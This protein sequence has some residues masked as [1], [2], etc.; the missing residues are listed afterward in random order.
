MIEKY[1]SINFAIRRILTNLNIKDKEVAIDD[2]IEWIGEGLQYIGSYY[3]YCEKPAT[4]SITDYKGE[5]PCDFCKLISIKN[6]TDNLPNSFNK[7]LIGSTTDQINRS[8]HTFRDYNITGNVITTSYKTGFLFIKYLA[9]PLDENGLPMI[10]DDIN[11][12]DALMW[13]CAYQLSMQGYTFKN[14]KLNDI[15][16]TQNKWNR[17]CLQARASLNS[18]DPD[19]LERMKNIMIRFKPDLNQYYN[20]F[21]TLGKQQFQ[22]QVNDYRRNF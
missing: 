17:Y 18:P 15:D 4:I 9:I 6:S 3:Q 7:Q 21:N 19:A 14:S 5:L 13:K 8:T 1:I 16:F 11:Y 20:D 10:P 2:L 12:L 22:H